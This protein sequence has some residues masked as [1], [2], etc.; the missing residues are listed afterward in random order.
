MRYVPRQTRIMR[1][2]DL[3]IYRVEFWA[4]AGWW[5]PARWVPM[6]RYFV[7]GGSYVWEGSLTDARQI[8]ADFIQSEWERI[9]RAEQNWIQC[10]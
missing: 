10:E 2:G 7:D 3:L 8:R 9:Y 5:K 6:R 1:L 4:D